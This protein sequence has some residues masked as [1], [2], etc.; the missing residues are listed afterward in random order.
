ME[1]FKRYKS[2]IM[3]VVQ[4]SGSSDP[5][6]VREAYK[7]VVGNHMT[8]ILKEEK[9]KMLRQAVDDGTMLPGGGKGGRSGDMKDRKKP[10]D[11]YSEQGLHLLNRKGIN[12]DQFLQKVGKTMPFVKLEENTKPKRTTMFQ[13]GL[14]DLEKMKAENA[15]I[16]EEIQWT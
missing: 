3:T 16:E 14:N 7:Y 2:E 11:V 12:A 1:H 4:K 10:E 15:Q 8:E 5:A 13:D 9:E 6:V